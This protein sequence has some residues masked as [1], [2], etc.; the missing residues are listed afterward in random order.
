M[1]GK[2]S[3]PTFPSLTRALFTARLRGGQ[4][5]SVCSHETTTL[6]P[7]AIAPGRSLVPMPHT[8][9][10]VLIPKEALI[11]IAS[12]LSLIHQQEYIHH[13][14]QLFYVSHYQRSMAPKSFSSLG[15]FS[16]HF[17]GHLLILPAFLPFSEP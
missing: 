11:R 14:L 10:D 2:F 17:S 1:P 13:T 6:C 7:H 15:Q 9:H 5:N 12:P 16:P 8:S 4:E 3:L